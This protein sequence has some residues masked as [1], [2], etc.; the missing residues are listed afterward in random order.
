LHKIIFYIVISIL[1]AGVI[2]SCEQKPSIP[3]LKETYSRTDKKPFGA[4]VMYTVLRQIF[5]DNSIRN[6]SESFNN[7]W[8]YTQDNNSL[9]ISITKRLFLSNEDEVAMLEYV[10]AGNDL[11]IATENI[12]DQLLNKIGCK[13]SLDYSSLLS[14]KPLK[15]TDVTLL[16]P[17]YQNVRYGYFYLPFANHFYD[18][19][20]PNV[21]ILAY[22][23]H[24]KPNCLVFFYGKGKLFLHCEPRAFSNY[25]LLTKNNYQYFKNLIRYTKDNPDYIYWDD[26]YNKLTSKKENT[27]FSAL[28]TVFK[29]PP[30]KLA[31]WLTLLLAVLFILFQG[32]RRQKIIQT[33]KPNEN[34]SVA[35]TETIGRLYLQKK[36]NYNIAQKM[37]TYFNE[38]IRNNYFLN[39][40]QVNDEFIIT[41]S[42]K[43]G[44][45]KNRVE[46]L[47]RSIYSVQSSTQVKDFELLSLNEQIQSF[48]RNSK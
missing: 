14:E 34:T 42:R 8:K 41:L 9:Y 20:N 23:E 4:Y 25:F 45:D 39:A 29:H 32:K 27:D 38:H 3:D 30:L 18:I 46:S 10:S 26:Y 16:K 6:E 5:P 22:N 15:N 33:I 28:D 12:S 40:N 11:F 7:V 35:F 48:I 37:I 17:P 19:T 1:L 13:L 36:D 43:S 47:Y 24:G 44:V 21:K 2:V 31:F